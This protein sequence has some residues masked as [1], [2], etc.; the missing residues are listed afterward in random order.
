MVVVPAG[1]FRMGSAPGEPGHE[2]DE[3]PP[4]E[5]TIAEPFAIGRHEVTRGQYRAFAEATGHRTQEGCLVWLV[6]VSLD[7]NKSWQDDVSGTEDDLP[8]ACVSVEDALAYADW[9]SAESGASYRLPSEAEFY[10]AASGG[11]GTAYAW[12]DRLEDA[13]AHGNVY[14]RSGRAAMPLSPWRSLDCDDGHA[15]LAPVGSYRANG[16]GLHD[17]TGNASEYVGDC[18]AATLDGLPADGSYRRSG[19][20]CNRVP[21]K[22]GSNWAAAD[23]ATPLADRW[24]ADRRDGGF[25]WTGFR[26]VRELD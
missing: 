12:G 19:G 17:T 2:A 7:R 13:C 10:W 23:L 22:G 18:Y 20:D 25:E 14:D 5:V 6:V 9:L 4:L 15:H 8:V 21:L 24:V 1:S 26:L 3:G 11:A 16:F